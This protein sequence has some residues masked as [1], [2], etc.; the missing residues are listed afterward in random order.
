LIKERD[1]TDAI[2]DTAALLIFV[3]DREGKIT[4]C[5][6]ASEQITGYTW[7]ELGGRVFWEI[8]SVE[9]EKTEE[10]IRQLLEGDF[11]IANESNWMM[12]NGVERLISWTST[13]LMNSESVVEYIVTTGIDV[14]ERRRAEI[15]LQDANNKL[16]AWVSELEEKTNDISLLSEMGGYLQGC[17]NLEEACAISA[18]YIAKMCPFS[19]GAIYLISPSKDLAEAYQIWGAETTT[20]K[21]F[22]PLDCWAVRRGRMNLVDK[23]HPGLFCSHITGPKDGRYICLPMTPT[24]K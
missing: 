22:P 12:K 15:E 1:F 24:E 8:F 9:P 23:E 5:N 13:V 3:L 21:L 20:Q 18:Q 11:P 14:T 2:L 7:R 6:K 16:T 4:R 17:Q 19:S 10:Q